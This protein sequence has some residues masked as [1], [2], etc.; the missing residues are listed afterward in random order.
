MSYRHLSTLAVVV[1]LDVLVH[2]LGTL[3]TALFTITLHLVHLAVRAP[4]L[5]VVCAH[6]FAVNA[7][8]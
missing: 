5:V 3:L 4:R 7:L 2:L 6:L 8:Y 1:Y